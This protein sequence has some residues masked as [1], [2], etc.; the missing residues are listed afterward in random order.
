MKPS[1]AVNVIRWVAA[2][3]ALGVWSLAVPVASMAQAPTQGIRVHGRWVI[4]VRNADG[5]LAVRREFENALF[6]GGRTT[7]AT[8]LT[9]QRAFDYW[10]VQI[11]ASG[12][13]LCLNNTI[14]LIT[15]PLSPS[16]GPNVFKNLTKTV[17]N[18]TLVLR[19]SFVAAQDGA[20]STVGTY[21]QTLSPEGGV[22]F[23]QATLQAPI[24]VQA[25]Q[26][27]SVTVTFSFS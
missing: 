13:E 19:G 1:H 27:V 2:I 24:P 9:A 11:N 16:S 7:L 4:E 17:V 22:G 3:A 18:S 10:Q 15:E 12:G 8:L 14:C 20:V 6:G 25:T 21:T 5:T 23:T 26:S